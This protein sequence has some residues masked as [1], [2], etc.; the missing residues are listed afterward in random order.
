M[1]IKTKARY[2]AALIPFIAEEENRYYL[3]GI[4]V[5]P[6]PEGGIRI[7]ATDGHALGVIYDADG[8]ADKEYILEINKTRIISKVLLDAFAEDI[9][10]D[11]FDGETVTE[12]L[13]L[14]DNIIIENGMAIIFKHRNSG[15]LESVKCD[16]LDGTF[17]DIRKVFD[18]CRIGAEL[19][20]FAVNTEILNKFSAAAKILT[21]RISP[22]IKMYWSG[23]KDDHENNVDPAFVLLRSPLFYGAI[24]PVMV[25]GCEYPAPEIPS[26][27]LTPTEKEK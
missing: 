11:H 8:E 20:Y 6:M 21:G 24:M 14:A 4:N 16:T 7:A 23:G 2:L 18:K 13:D 19:K 22:H 17:P 1:F 5:K 3:N 12:I 9:T 27:L 26:W 10:V 15:I 25:N